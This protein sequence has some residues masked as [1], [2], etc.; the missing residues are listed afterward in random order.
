[1]GLLKKLCLSVCI[2]V[3]IL[4]VQPAKSTVNIGFNYHI[5]MYGNYYYQ[6]LAVINFMFYPTTPYKGRVAVQFYTN[7]NAPILEVLGLYN[8]A[9]IGTRYV[10]VARAYNDGRGFFTAYINNVNRGQMQHY[11]IRAVDGWGREYIRE[12]LRFLAPPTM[13]GYNVW[14]NMFMQTRYYPVLY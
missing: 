9:I 1:M 11:V 12:N 3:A 14:L 13:I 7:T 4:S 8:N 5:P 10:T 6:E 2:A